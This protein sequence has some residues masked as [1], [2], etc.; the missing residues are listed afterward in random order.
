[1]VNNLINSINLINRFFVRLGPQ[2][3]QNLFDLIYEKLIQLNELK[4]INNKIVGFERNI[5]IR[6]KQSYSIED[7]DWGD[8]QAH[9]KLVGLI[10]VARSFNKNE[11]ESI[12][13]LHKTIHDTYNNTLF[14]S[15]CFIIQSLDSTE[16]TT[17]S[18]VCEIF[19][20]HVDFN[21]FFT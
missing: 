21:L 5:R 9:R 7:N 10:T 6:Y 19:F 17:E 4:I 18:E 1:M 8:F 14:D 3:N 13:E 12:S 15:K 20:F 2:M 16:S 11:I